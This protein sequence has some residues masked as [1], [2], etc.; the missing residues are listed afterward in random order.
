MLTIVEQLLATPGSK[1]VAAG[2]TSEAGIAG[3]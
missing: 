1:N 2:L 3:A